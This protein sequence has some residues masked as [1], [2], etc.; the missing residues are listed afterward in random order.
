MG[1][2]G[3][4]WSTVNP[5]DDK[6]GAFSGADP[7]YQTLGQNTPDQR[8]AQQSLYNSQSNVGNDYWNMYGQG[9][10]DRTLANV[11]Q[12]QGAQ[13]A[14]ADASVNAGQIYGQQSTQTGQNYG[15][16]VAGTGQ[17]YGQAVNENSSILGQ[18]MTNYGQQQGAGIQGY[19]LGQA[20]GLGGRA[21]ALGGMGQQIYGQGMQAQGRDITSGYQAGLEGIERQAGPSA[22]QAQLQSGLNRA[23]AESLAQ[24]RSGRGWGGSASM[25]RQ[26]ANLQ[27]QMGQEAANQS[28]TLRAQE[29]AAQ[30]ARAAQNIQ[31]AGQLGL[32]QAAANDAREAA[33]LGQ[34]VAAQTQAGQLAA[35]GAGLGLQG[36]QGGAGLGL[37]GTIAGGQTAI[38]G[39]LAGGQLA[40]QATAQGG[41]LALRGLGQGADAELGGYAQGGNLYGQAGDIGLKGEA[42]MGANAAQAA[43]FDQDYQNR[44]LAAA[45]LNAQQQ[46]A[47][48][49]QMMQIFGGL[50]GMGGSALGAFTGSDRNIKKD[51]EPTN[52]DEL[53][54][55]ATAI[56][57]QDGNPY[58]PYGQGT[59]ISGPN[60]AQ[61]G[62]S[63]QAA[64]AA[65][66]QS[67]QSPTGESGGDGKA[68]KALGQGMMAFG[69]QLSQP[70]A[71]IQ[72][73]PAQQSGNTYMR[74]LEMS[75]RNEKYAASD[76]KAKEA[77]EKTPGYKFRYKDPDAMGAEEGVQFGIMAQDLEKTPA[78]RSVV[79]KQ[80]DGTRMVDT[81]RLALLEAGAM[82]ALSKKV[83]ELE[84]MVRGK[85]A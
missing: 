83:A 13:R 36:M 11:A 72:F 21:D 61:G 51:I 31:A 85:A 79:K 16:Q 25:A 59:G 77:I 5:F 38:Q 23:S 20:Q 71:P 26:G 3:D 34:G 60:Q 52:D 37:E 50:M 19:A 46:Q 73:V 39:Q 29:D 81:S 78:G 7:G 14:L 64:T 17:A 41:D 12:T 58:D 24:A 15:A 76:E 9:G 6:G 2:L 42:L 47:S 27:A 75:D 43:S 40:T 74:P 10:Q 53:I 63:N 65:S 35:Q 44:L 18:G 84:R 82:N 70:G 66:V 8:A 54:V 69:E 49:Q 45:G 48:N 55:P 62:A 22:A 4:A 68:G 80:P 57:D 28:A 1:L 67:P 32:G 56:V 33:L 30:R